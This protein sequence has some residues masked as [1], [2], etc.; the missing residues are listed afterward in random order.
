MEIKPIF[1]T[2]GRHK[3]TVC[4]LIAQIALTCAIV[5]NAIFLISQRLDRMAVSS[6]M[7]EHELVYM[8]LAFI[9]AR[10]NAMARTQ[11]D[12]SALREVPGVQSAM[13]INHLPLSGS[14]SNSSLWLDPAQRMETMSA[15]Q[16]F[17]ENLLSTLGVQLE[18]GREFSPE[19]YRDLDKIDK[20]LQTGDMKEIPSA[21]LITRTV[22]D[23]LWPGQSPL[24]KQV[25]IGRN[26][27][28]TVVGVVKGLARPNQLE[29]GAQYSLIHPVR[30][31]M[32]AGSYYVL[33][34]AAQDRERVLKA[35]LA[36]LNALDP[37]RIVLDKGS[38]DE[39]RYNFFRNDRAMAGIL[40]GVCLALLVVT[41]L[42]IVG[43]AS[44][45]VSQRNR[46][47]GVRRALGATRGHI[48]NYFQTENFLLT[49]MGIVLGMLLA[50]AINLFL[51]VHY[52]L[53]RLPLAYFPVGAVLL[54]CLG[55]AA[56]LGPALRAAA[57][58]PV[59]AT[60]SV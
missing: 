4:L 20:A 6:G 56:V 31:S 35:A 26:F 7:A 8:Q 24:G 49:S 23:R 51:I 38:W 58:P 55:Q 13:I 12:L 42:G 47:I 22:A 16:Y 46:S 40:V 1:A 57:V 27:A 19:E 10:P 41:A 39:M 29:R 5:C 25:F 60:R 36:K 52:E 15:T 59:V 32:S 3:F 44:F 9:G 11:A 37:N 43:L 50:Y 18:A 53:P 2:L 48:L 17:G 30:L 28:L 14:S 33:R 34:C 54:W 21:V 45:W